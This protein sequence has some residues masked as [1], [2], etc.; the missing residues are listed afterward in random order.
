MGVSGEIN[1]QLQEKRI[2][3]NCIQNKQITYR[4]TDNQSDYVIRNLRE[5][6]IRLLD[7]FLLDFFFAISHFSFY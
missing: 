2:M 1:K 6:E 7:D 5:S 4:T 3:N